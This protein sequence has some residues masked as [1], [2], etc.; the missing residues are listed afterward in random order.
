MDQNTEMPLNTVDGIVPIDPVEQQRKEEFE[1]KQKEIAE[2]N[3]ILKQTKIDE[4]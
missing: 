3:E 1:K 2:A 4:T